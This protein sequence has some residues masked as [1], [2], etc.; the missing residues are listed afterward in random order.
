MKYQFSFQATVNDVAVNSVSEEKKVQIAAES[1]PT[2][3]TSGA[4]AV[5]T[6]SIQITGITTGASPPIPS[7]TGS[8]E[9]PFKPQRVGS[10]FARF[11]DDIFQVIKIEIYSILYREIFI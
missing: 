6:S 7:L 9:T 1:Q 11:I 5:P 3:A 2:A 4:P 8:E 10:M